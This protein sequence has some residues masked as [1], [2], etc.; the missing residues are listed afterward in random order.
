MIT[1][2]PSKFT[3][4]EDKEEDVGLFRAAQPGGQGHYSPPLKNAPSALFPRAQTI[5]PYCNKIGPD[6]AVL[7]SVRPSILLQFEG[8]KC[9][10]MRGESADFSNFSEGVPPDPPYRVAVAG[11]IL[12]VSSG[13][14]A[15]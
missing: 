15:P 5:R 12:R 9:A 8:R 6:Q 11:Y 4:L 10:Q 2:S 13:V 14:V 1:L 3:I 7:V